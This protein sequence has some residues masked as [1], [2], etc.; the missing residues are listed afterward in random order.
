M[1]E[2]VVGRIDFVVLVVAVLDKEAWF[3]LAEAFLAAAL[4]G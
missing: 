1:S 3:D 2:Q 4:Q